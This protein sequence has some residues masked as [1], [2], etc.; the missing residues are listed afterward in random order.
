[1]IRRIICV[2]CCALLLFSCTAGC[3]ETI[4]ENNS[5]DFDLVF[6]LNAEAFPPVL[7]SR[8]QGYADLLDRI[9]L[10]GSIAW[11][12]PNN[13]MDLNATL[14]FRDK[15]SVSF[16][17]RL[18]GAAPRLFLTSPLIRD[19]ILFLNMAG[20]LEFAVKAKNTL[21]ISMPYVAILYPYSTEYA[22]SALA[23]EWNEV[24]EPSV[25]SGSVSPQQFEQLSGL[26]DTELQENQYLQIWINA[27]ADGSQAP[28]TISSL[29]SSLP[30]YYR[31]VTGGQPL[32]VQRDEHSET[33]RTAAGD[34]LF[35]RLEQDHRFSVSLSLP[36]TENCYI[37]SFS[38]SSEKDQ[39]LSSFDLAVSVLRDENAQ[40]AA[41]ET[42]DEEESGTSGEDDE[43]YGDYDYSDYG[44]DEDYSSY[45][46]YE[47]E[48]YGSDDEKEEAAYHSGSSADDPDTLLKC[49]V[50]GRQLPLTL[51]SDSAFTVTA[52][53]E[54]AA[55]PNYSFVIRGETKED[56][57]LSLLLCKPQQGQ[58]DPEIILSCS[59]TLVPAGDKEV[60]NYMKHPYKQLYNV[61]SFNE[62]SLADFNSKVI[63]PLVKSVFSFIAEAPT[64]ACQ[65]FLD[66]LSESGILNMLLH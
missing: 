53:L 29:F 6:S 56:H 7:R 34:T 64:S 33:W 65:S 8:V 38:F 55:Y 47:E 59:G 61:F 3:A 62:E 52:S 35:S 10:K 66:D 58:A 45:D 13:S 21:N 12:A 27:L 30:S 41:A 2:L 20:F 28:S 39:D 11:S 36:A 22:F 50:A 46:D 24:I 16:P 18:Y 57:S 48:D 51:P 5:V 32:T 9:G 19:E 23:K 42:A 1:M 31:Q 40:P 15:P 60:P 17:F 14:Y 49:K 26:W 44:E 37:P 4:S 63:P 43:D 54:G 25:E